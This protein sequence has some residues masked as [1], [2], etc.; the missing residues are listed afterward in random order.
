M[1]QVTTFG[2]RLRQLMVEQDLTYGEL[3]VRLGM[4]PQTLNRYV[5]D[6]RE[7][8]GSVTAEIALTFGVDPL[9]LQGFDTERCPAQNRRAEQLIP[10]LGV[11]R[12]GTPALAEEHITGYA[13]ASVSNPEECFYL[14][15]SGD[16]MI[17]AGIRDGDLVLIRQQSTAESG[18][19][20]ACMVD[21]GD[22]TL[23]RFRRQGDVVI[24]QPE[25]SNYEPRIVSLAEFEQG[26]ARII[27]VAIRLT[28]DL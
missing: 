24:L 10:V 6:Q 21:G 16:S 25:N 5:L 14:R 17:N 3:G 20:V 9:W 13:G 27:G 8:R 1:K 2:Q 18:Q 19:I 7:P 11:I 28:R 15:V 23:K 26:S 22:A 4:N 12:A